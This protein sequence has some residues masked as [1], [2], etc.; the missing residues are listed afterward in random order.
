[1]KSVSKFLKVSE[2]YTNNLKGIDVSIPLNAKI[3][4]VGPSGS[5]KSSLVFDTIG[6]EARTRMMSALFPHHVGFSPRTKAKFLT[7]LPPVVLLSQHLKPQHPYKKVA[8]Y[9][10][11]YPLLEFALAE[12]GELFCKNCKTYSRLTTLERVLNWFENLEDG[13]KFYFLTPIKASK[14]ALEFLLSQGYTKFFVN[15]TLLDISEEDPPEEVESAFVVI[16]RIIKEKGATSR[17]MENIRTAFSLG[18]GSIVLRFLT[19]KEFTFNLKSVCFKCGKPL[20][21]EFLACPVCK[22]AGYL[23]K[24]MCSSCKG[25]GLKE[26]VLFSRIEGK[27]IYELLNGTLREFKEKF[28]KDESVALRRFLKAE[29]FKVDYLTLSTPVFRLSALERKVLE[30]IEVFSLEIDGAL[31]LLDEPSLYLDFKRR[32]VLLDN[33]DELVKE[34]KTVVLVEHD[35]VIIESSDWILHLGPGAGEKGGFL[36]FSGERSEYTFLEKKF[37]V[38]KVEK[39]SF[40]KLNLNKSKRELSLVTPGL[41]LFFGEKFEDEELFKEAL[42]EL[43]LAGFKVLDAEA[44]RAV[45]GD[46]WLISYSGIW[47]EVK[48]VLLKLPSARAKGFGAKHLSFYSK[49]GKC[50]TCQGKGKKAFKVG[51]TWIEVKCETCMGYRL[52]PEVLSLEFK[53]FKLFEL[54]EMTFEELLEVFQGFYTIKDKLLEVKR[55]GLSYLKVNQEVSTLSG[56]E[57]SRLLILRE[58]FKKGKPDWLFVK[59]P[60]QGLSLWDLEFFLTWKD[61]LVEKGISL[62][63]LETNP[64][65]LMISDNL[66]NGKEYLEEVKKHYEKYFSFD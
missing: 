21:T 56:G 42:E 36:V 62:A 26:E 32:K 59:Y 19:G 5:G 43:R 24:K 63:I 66:I 52:N 47:D 12:K 27:S 41:N 54:F 60:L 16:D 15:G 10:F 48:K 1:L 31:Y 53:G 3:C 38:K 4:V 29:E 22:G 2:V 58:L 25:T 57:K 33:I 61:S 20:V 34:G 55:F 45:K 37:S 17:F 8:D 30:L 14:K 11:V 44:H 18:S 50:P 65:A 7:P 49:E 28:L 46:D 35:P 9:F 13:E 40:F 64:I 39:Q 23:E 6:R 51:E